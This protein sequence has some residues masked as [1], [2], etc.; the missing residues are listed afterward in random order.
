[1]TSKQLTV[2][3]VSVPQHA[4]T[5][6]ELKH[7][8]WRMAKKWCFQLE[9]GEETGYMHYQCR[10]SLKNKSRIKPCLKGVHPDAWSPTSKENWQNEFYTTK[11]DTRVD[12]PWSNK[13][14]VQYIPRQYRNIKLWEWQEEVLELSKN[15][16]DRTINL[17]IDTCGN[18]GK[19]TLASLSELTGKGIDVPPI[20]DFKEL[21]QVM[22]NICEGKELRDPTP[23][24][25]DLPRAQ[26]KS[27]L[28]G[29]FAAIEQIKKGKLVDMRY[30]YK[31]WWIDS[32]DIW[33]FTNTEPDLNLLSRDRWKL[34]EING[35]RTTGF[36][37]AL[38]CNTINLN[39]QTTWT[40]ELNY[41]QARLNDL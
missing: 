38:R 5:V 35:N 36:K 22:H 12:G 27:R 39:P 32:P 11:E 7:E 26:E 20:N 17:V 29:I 10:I 31:E 6:N 19:S 21:L 16:C 9:K 40:R 3:D 25:I 24:F 37:L 33:V 2:W 34:W 14:C 15:F 1:M 30:H 23:I 41:Q 18:T 4:F 13:D 28:H 8:F